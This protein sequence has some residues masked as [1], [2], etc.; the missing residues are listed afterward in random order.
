MAYY[1]SLFHKLDRTANNMWNEL[2]VCCARLC[3][4]EVIQDLRQ[5]YED[6]LIEPFLIRPEQ[7]EKAFAAGRDAAMGNLKNTNPLISDAESEMSW[8]PCFREDEE[9]PEKSKPALNTAPAV[10]YPVPAAPSSPAPYRIER[11]EPIRN[12]SS[13][14]GRNESCPCESGKKYKKCCGR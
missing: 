8:W 10:L 3:P 5:A 13:K 2:A 7:I 9:T 12:T 14:I 6:N 1:G 4:T 11:Q